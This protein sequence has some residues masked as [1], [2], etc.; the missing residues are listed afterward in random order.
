MKPHSIPE[1]MP[2]PPRWGRWQPGAEVRLKALTPEEAWAVAAILEDL[3]DS[4]WRFHGRAMADYQGGVFPY[5]VPA[6]GADPEEVAPPPPE[7]IDDM[8]F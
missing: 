4:I 3:L 5:W 1:R 7:A 2:L 6:R 8:A